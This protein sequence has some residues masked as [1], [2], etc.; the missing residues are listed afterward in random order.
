MRHDR[1]KLSTDLDPPGA[2]GDAVSTPEQTKEALLEECDRDLAQIW[3]QVWN[4]IE[5]LAEQGKVTQ[6]VKER[7][8]SR[9][10]AGQKITEMLR[11]ER[12]ANRHNHQ[13]AVAKALSKHHEDRALHH[14]REAERFLKHAAT[15]RTEYVQEQPI[16]LPIA[17]KHASMDR[18]QDG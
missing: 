13:G 3:A 6:A 16:R 18:G 14:A 7:M 12:E 2:G 10:C 11:W 5:Y 9:V 15:L 8:Q 4:E 1:S 17:E